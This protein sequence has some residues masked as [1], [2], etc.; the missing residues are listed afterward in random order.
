MKSLKK[1]WFILDMAEA[2][3]EKKPLSP[4]AQAQSYR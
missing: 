1:A 3:L 2:E 4:E